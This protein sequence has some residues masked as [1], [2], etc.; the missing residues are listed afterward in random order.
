MALFPYLLVIAVFSV[1]KLVP[2]VKDFLAG[3]DRKDPLARAG[4]DVLTVAGR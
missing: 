1:A 4:R 2:A 3:T